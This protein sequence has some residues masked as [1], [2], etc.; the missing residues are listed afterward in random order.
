MLGEHAGRLHGFGVH[1][2]EFGADFQSPATG[3]AQATG[4]APR[5]ELSSSAQTLL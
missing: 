4:P 1:P 5:P 2:T 3:P